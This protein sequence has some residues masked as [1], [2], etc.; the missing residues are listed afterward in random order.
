M[1]IDFTFAE[2]VCING[3][4]FAMNVKLKAQKP[5]QSNRLIL[6]M[7]ENKYQQISLALTIFFTIQRNIMKLSIYFT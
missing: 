3:V 7:Y 2:L 6:D 4:Q 5:P 1:T